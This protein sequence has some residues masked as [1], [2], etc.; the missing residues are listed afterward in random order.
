MVIQNRPLAIVA[1][2]AERTAAELRDRAKELREMAAMGSDQRLQEALLLV[3]DEF[4]Q[5]AAS[6]DAGKSRAHKRS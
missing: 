4:E 2:M 5:E 1:L 6:L 3:A